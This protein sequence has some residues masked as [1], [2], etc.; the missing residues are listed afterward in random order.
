MH[1]PLNLR[2]LPLLNLF[3]NNTVPYINN[4]VSSVPIPPLPA[5]SFSSLP[6]RSLALRIRRAILSYVG[7]VDELR[8]DLAHTVVNPNPM[9]G[10][11][12][13]LP[14]GDFEFV[15]NWRS[16]NFN[17]LDFSGACVNEKDRNGETKVTFVI[18]YPTGVNRPLRGVA[19][20]ISEDDEAVWLAGARGRKEWEAIRQGGEV[21][22]IA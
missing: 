8:K 7:D 21:A 12:P 20:V 13:C 18:G 11:M 4:A 22:F 14:N 15:S 3:S 17:Q 19:I 1:L 5:S 2:P 9:K 10:S 6:L 16:A